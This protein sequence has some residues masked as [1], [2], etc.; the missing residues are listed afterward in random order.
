MP[1]WTRR[2]PR[3]GGIGH[4]ADR[5][6]ACLSRRPD[7]APGPGGHGRSGGRPGSRRGCGPAP[8]AGRLGCCGRRSSTVI[9]RSAGRRRRNS[10]SS[11]SSTTGDSAPRTSRTGPSMRS[12]SSHSEPKSTEPTCMP[13]EPAG[14]P[15][16]WRQVQVPSSRWTELWRT[17]RR[18]EDSDRVGLNWMVRSRISSKEAKVS[19]PARKAA[20]SELFSWVDPRGDVDQGQLAPPA[21]DGPAARAMEVSP[22]ERHP[23]HQ[24]G[25]GGQA[26][27][28][29]G[30]VLGH[31]RRDRARSASPGQSEWPCPGRSTATSG[32][33]RARATVSQ[34]WAFWPPPWMST[35]SAVAV[36]HTRA[37]TRAARRHLD[38][39]PPHGGRA[40]PGET[41][42]RWRSPRTARTR[43]SGRRRS[44]SRWDPD[45]VG[46][47]GRAP[48]TSSPRVSS[49]IG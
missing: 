26:V 8:G 3:L 15:S 46:G 4:H 10:A 47:R 29:R 27:D 45:R 12:R 30:H 9:T 33:P 44:R 38:R 24:P 49:A 17:P 41:R 14:R 34:V 18:S 36:P 42:P 7:P 39:L 40:R 6:A 21:R 20:M 43:R 31:G 2:R 19:G 48:P 23:H 13:L 11:A 37:L 32:R 5:R 22:A 1:R 28:D 25:R 16:W 35:S